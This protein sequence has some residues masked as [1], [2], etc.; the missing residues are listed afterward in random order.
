MLREGGRLNTYITILVRQIF[1]S[2]NIEHL[3]FAVILKE[4][5]LIH[6]LSLVSY[7][8]LHVTWI[9]F[10]IIY[11]MFFLATSV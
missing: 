10:Q 5:P 2:L 9:Y 8:Y 6:V 4:F 1:W 11:G 7:L 3:I